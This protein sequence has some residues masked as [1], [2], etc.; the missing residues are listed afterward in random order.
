MVYRVSGMEMV[1]CVSAVEMVYCVSGVEMVYR[2]S[3]VEMVYCVSGVERPSASKIPL[4]ASC[5]ILFFFG[6]SFICSA[7]LCPYLSCTLYKC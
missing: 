6:I 1:Y 5:C 4:H 2:V 3:G 7:L